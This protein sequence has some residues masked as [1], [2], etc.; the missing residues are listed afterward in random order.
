MIGH[1]INLLGKKM[2]KKQYDKRKSFGEDV[3]ELFPERRV[4]TSYSNKECEDVGND[5]NID[6]Y[7]HTIDG[8]PGRL[9]RGIVYLSF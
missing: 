8:S 2:S 4:S 3:A 5:I 9:V 6:E 1:E 7:K